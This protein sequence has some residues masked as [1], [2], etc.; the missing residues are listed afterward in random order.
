MTST[1]TTTPTQQPKLPRGVVE[2]SKVRRRAKSVSNAIRAPKSAH[3]LPKAP[4]S[5]FSTPRGR[6]VLLQDPGEQGAKAPCSPLSF[7]CRI[8]D[9]SLS[10]AHFPLSIFHCHA[11]RRKLSV[12]AATFSIFVPL[13]AYRRKVSVVTVVKICVSFWSRRASPAHTSLGGP[14]LPP[15]AR[16]GASQPSPRGRP[17]P[18]APWAAGRPWPAAPSRPPGPATLEGRGKISKSVL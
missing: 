12:A 10:I 3:T 16:R 13:R 11:Y 14:A 9:F 15:A 8:V 2:G 17:C 5:V 7:H 6:D 18:A 4:Q 1:R